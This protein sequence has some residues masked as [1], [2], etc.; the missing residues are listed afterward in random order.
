MVAF[1]IFIIVFGFCQFD[2]I[3]VPAM[4]IHISVNILG[5]SCFGIFV[6]LNIFL[7]LVNW[8]NFLDILKIGVK[9]F[10]ISY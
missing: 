4:R 2:S 3:F 6:K 8:C 1:N 10:F 7:N 9:A 5:S